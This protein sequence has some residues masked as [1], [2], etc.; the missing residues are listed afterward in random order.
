MHCKQSKLDGI[1][2]I[3]IR[4]KNKEHPAIARSK[5]DKTTKDK[6]AMQ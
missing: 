3:Q 1:F 2:Q 4:D 5:I 6:H